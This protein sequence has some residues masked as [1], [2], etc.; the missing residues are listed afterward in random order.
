MASGKIMTAASRL[1]FRLIDGHGYFEDVLETV[2]GRAKL[3]IRWCSPIRKG[4]VGK[5]CFITT[6]KLMKDDFDMG[7]RVLIRPFKKNMHAADVYIF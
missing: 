4:M 6:Q 1:N 7:V 3:R 5:T 2:K